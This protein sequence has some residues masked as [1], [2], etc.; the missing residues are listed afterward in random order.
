CRGRL[1]PERHRRGSAWLQGL[2]GRPTQGGQRQRP[3]GLGPRIR[4]DRGTGGAEVTFSRPEE[5]TL[6]VIVGKRSRGGVPS[7]S[8]A[9]R[10]VRQASA[11]GASLG[12]G[13]LG[14]GAGV[15]AGVQALFGIGLF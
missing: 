11:P 2:G 3:A 15:I 14:V 5:N 13:Y 7:A 1:R 12:T 10:A 4:N 9:G 8:T 6:G